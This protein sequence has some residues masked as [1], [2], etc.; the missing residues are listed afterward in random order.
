MHL[1]AAGAKKAKEDD[2]CI[3]I[4]RNSILNILKLR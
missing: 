4:T 2:P 1:N 3:W